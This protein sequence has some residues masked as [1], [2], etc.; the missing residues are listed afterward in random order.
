M[1]VAVYCPFLASAVLGVT[2]PWLARRLPPATASRLLAAGGLGAALATVS[3]LAVLTFLV[4]ARVPAVAEQGH[5]SSGALDAAV[6]VPRAVAVVALPALAVAVVRTARLVVDRGRAMAAARALCRELGGTPGQ[7][8]V[9][10]DDVAAVAVPAAGGRVLVSRAQLAAL[11]AVERRALLL[12]ERAHLAHGHHRHR[13]LAEG[14]AALDPLQARLPGAVRFATE[15]WA[16]ESAAAELGDR[17]AVARALARSGLRAQRPVP[18]PWAAV[19]LGSGGSRVVQ[20]VEALL[21][22][23]PRQRPVVLVAALLV[24]AFGP[25]TAVHA[26]ADTEEVV[27]HAVPADLPAAR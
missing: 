18:A 12:H 15:R 4:L 6:P 2:S 14:A 20:R 16:D 8:V 13:F 21:A 25:A 24:V 26:Q 9:V 3:A 19:A 11:P 10:E 5:W 7:L 27:E 17:S 1:H 22:P 23:A